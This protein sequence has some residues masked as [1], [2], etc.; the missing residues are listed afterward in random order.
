MEVGRAVSRR[1]PDRLGSLRSIFD[2]GRLASTMSVPA[3][4]QSSVFVGFIWSF[5]GLVRLG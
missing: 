2:A 3:V 5:R 1:Y 4:H